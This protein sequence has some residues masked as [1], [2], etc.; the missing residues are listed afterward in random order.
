[1][2]FRYKGRE[3]PTGGPSGEAYSTEETRIGTWIDGKPIYKRVF[4][5]DVPQCIG[6]TEILALDF[7]IDTLIRQ[8]AIVKSNGALAFRSLAMTTTGG[9]TGVDSVSGNG[10]VLITGP[11]HK[12]KPNTLLLKMPLATWAGTLTLIIE[13][14]KVTE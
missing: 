9:S 3:I 7:S 10:Y 5:L 4:S 1:M 11:G 12:T 8:S 13:Y 14:T 2:S 6:E